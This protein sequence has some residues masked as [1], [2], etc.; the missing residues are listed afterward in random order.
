M[1]RVAAGEELFR[2]SLALFD[3]R[4]REHLPTTHLPLPEMREGPRPVKMSRDRRQA[5]CYQCHAP[6]ATWQARSGD[7]RTPIDWP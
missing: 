5:L 7:D 4:T 3:L 2:P 6:L 1:V